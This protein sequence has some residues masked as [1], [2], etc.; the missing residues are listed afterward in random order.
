MSLTA[1]SG[2]L[3]R[4]RFSFAELTFLFCGMTAR[5]GEEELLASRASGMVIWN[6]KRLG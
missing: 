1:L 3:L 5:R 6:A 2:S 4:R